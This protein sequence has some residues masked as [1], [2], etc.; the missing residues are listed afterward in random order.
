MYFISY[1]VCNFVILCFEKLQTSVYLKKKIPR[2]FS[3]GPAV[4]TPYF[5]CHSP[6]SVP[7]GELRSPKL[8]G[9]AKKK[10][11]T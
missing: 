6:G 4:R 11:P 2:E 7:V 10:N 5:H 1:T 3:G 8:H 9:T